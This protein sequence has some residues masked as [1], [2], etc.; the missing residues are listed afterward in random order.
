MA[1]TKKKVGASTE[2]KCIKQAII[3]LAKA[4]FP[5]PEEMDGVTYVIRIDKKGEVEGV[6]V[7][8]S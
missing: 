3:I 2:G 8:M 1:K 7:H 6:D 4:G 5:N